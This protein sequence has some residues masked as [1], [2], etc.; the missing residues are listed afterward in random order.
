MIKKTLLAFLLLS[1]NVNALELSIGNTLSTNGYVDDSINAMVKY[2]MY[3]DS[4]RIDVGVRVKNTDI[5]PFASLLYSGNYGYWKIG[6][7]DEFYGFLSKD[8]VSFSGL[9]I[10]P[11]GVYQQNFVDGGF[12]MANGVSGGMWHNIGN[13]RL[14][15][16]I[17][18]GTPYILNYD[19]YEDSLLGSNDSWAN[20]REGLSTS[21]HVSY[22]YSNNFS[23]M[24]ARNRAEVNVVK[25]WE[26]GLKDVFL[27]A[28]RGSAALFL[29]P[30]YVIDIQRFG[31][32]VGLS[33][34]TE[35]VVEKA[36]LRVENDMYDIP[37]SDNY[38]I[39]LYHSLC[40]RYEITMGYSEGA[41]EGRELNNDVHVGL[42]MRYSNLM[43][44]I[45]YH[46][47]YGKSWFSKTP[48]SNNNDVFILT[49]RYEL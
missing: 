12:S 9:A 5:S 19:K 3:Y 27:S 29:S 7:Y 2:E 15:W 20:L 44:A 31:I 16:S 33:D 47:I 43:G 22:Q 10:L 41:P 34:K 30:D 26:W 18:A 39:L 4:A 38:Y 11:Q 48:A 49:W 13:H 36:L 40:P 17:S 8:D 28:N 25:Q 1:S 6:T 46:H 24:Y 45:E 42:N 14:E 37:G 21:L 35:I 32:R 23:L